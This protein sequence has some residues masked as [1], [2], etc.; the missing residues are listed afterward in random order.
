MF[1]WTAC[2]VDVV[3]V[4]LHATRKTLSDHLEILLLSNSS[5]T[6]FQQDV[7]PA[8]PASVVTNW[9]GEQF[10]L[11][12][13]GRKEP[14]PW[15]PRSSDLT[16]AGFILWYYVKRKVYNPV[17]EM[18]DNRKSRIQS[19]CELI[20][21]STPGTC[22]VGGLFSIILMWEWLLKQGT[23]QLGIC[24]RCFTIERRLK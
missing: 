21:T 5:W 19:V 1:S 17:L 22:T 15:S 16:P 11:R 12:W 20:P 9:L 18:L 6:L 7:A 24:K 8:H 23:I 13:I 10:R 2:R 14:V 3:T 4:F